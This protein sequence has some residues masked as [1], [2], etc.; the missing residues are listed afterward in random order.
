MRLLFTVKVISAFRGFRRLLES[1]NKYLLDLEILPPLRA[2]M[3]AVSADSFE[4]F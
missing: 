1:A 2:E 3:A 4:N